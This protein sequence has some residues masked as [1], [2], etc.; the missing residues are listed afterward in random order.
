MMS[1]HGRDPTSINENHEDEDQLGATTRESST[2][3]PPLVGNAVFHIIIVMFHLI[4]MKNLL[5]G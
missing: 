1:Q 2:C 3:I 4:Q 5:K